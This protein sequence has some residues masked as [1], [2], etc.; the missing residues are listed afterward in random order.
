VTEYVDVTKPF[1]EFRAKGL[2]PDAL[3]KIY[4]AYLN[5][6]PEPPSDSASAPDVAISA[7]DVPSIV[8]TWAWIE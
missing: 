4:A 1:A 6:R 5:I 8:Y 7:E 3:R 2:T